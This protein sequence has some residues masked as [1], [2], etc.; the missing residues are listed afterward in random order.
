MSTAEGGTVE[1]ELVALATAGATALVEQMATDGWMRVRDRV[2][3]FFAGR[4]TAS[5]ESIEAELETA[6]AELTAA[7]QEGD[8][9]I[10]DDLR[11]EW[12]NRLR[13]TLRADP[14]SAAELRALVDE[15]T[16]APAAQQFRDVYNTISGG[17]HY[18]TIQVGVQHISGQG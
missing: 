3:G 17:T 18:G 6:R 12:R 8:E 4:G 16:P 9:Q 11:A 7:R 5:P 2:V 10:D 13:R 14:E 15:L 1:A